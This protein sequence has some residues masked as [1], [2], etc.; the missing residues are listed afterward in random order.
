MSFL[1]DGE[2]ALSIKK[3]ELGFDATLKINEFG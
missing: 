2:L 1:T 3:F